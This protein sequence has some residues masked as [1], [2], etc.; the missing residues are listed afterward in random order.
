MR[1]SL[2]WDITQRRLVVTDVL[3]HF[4]GP[5]FWG[6]V[7]MGTKVCPV[8]SVPKYRCTLRNI[9]KEQRSQGQTASMATVPLSA[10]ST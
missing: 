3:G 2:F 5:F 4:V 8:T 6:Q 7:N 1:S 10:P 9:L